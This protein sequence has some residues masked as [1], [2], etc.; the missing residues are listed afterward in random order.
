MACG[1]EGKSGAEAGERTAGE[2][3]TEE[4]VAESTTC[5]REAP[6]AGPRDARTGR[7]QE[8]QPPGRRRG[9][10]CRFRKFERLLRSADFVRVLRRGRCFRAPALR[11]HFHEGRTEFSRLGLVV[12]RKMGRAVLRNR[13]KRRL[14]EVFRTSKARLPRPLD[15]V[16]V[17]DPRFGPASHEVYRESFDRFLSWLGSREAPPAPERPEERGPRREG[18]SRGGRE[19]GRGR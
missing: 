3:V 19:R 13:I 1:A 15:L 5:S 11:V 7:S 16:L 9:S 12:G 4:R 17:C 2:R 10:A 8:R 6:R 14:R 18:G